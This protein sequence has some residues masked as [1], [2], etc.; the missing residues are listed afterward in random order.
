MAKVVILMRL[1]P[2]NEDV[3]LD[4]LAKKLLKNLP[5][6]I[7]VKDV[8]R[9]PIAFGAE[10]LLVAFSIPDEEGYVQRLEDYLRSIDEIQEFIT[11]FISRL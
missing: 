8:R 9:E 4:E 11:E 3:N 6:N 2:S 10:S 1:L 5:E 7:E